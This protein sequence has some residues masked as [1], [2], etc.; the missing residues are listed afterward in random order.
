MSYIIFKKQL[1]RVYI[2]PTGKHNFDPEEL[3][4]LLQVNII[5]IRESL[6]Q[7]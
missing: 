4:H 2:F 3:T 7:P 5:L 6:P 1:G